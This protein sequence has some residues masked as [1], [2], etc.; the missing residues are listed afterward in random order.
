M[1][2]RLRRQESR[3]I[4]ADGETVVSTETSL[5]LVKMETPSAYC[6][7]SCEVEGVR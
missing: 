6:K 2:Q 1:P 5:L 4:D 7:L 3:S